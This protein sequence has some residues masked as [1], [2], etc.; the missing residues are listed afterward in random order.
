MP[1]RRSAAVFLLLGVAF[2][3][4]LVSRDGSN[5][6]GNRKRNRARRRTS[7]NLL[8]STTDTTHPTATN[9]P[10]C[11][12]GNPDGL[13]D[14]PLLLY[15]YSRTGS[16]WL[17]WSGKTLRSKTRP[18]RWTHEAHGKCLA[19]DSTAKTDDL[20]TW[21]AE[22][23]G[24][25][26][27]GSFIS[28]DNKHGMEP[29]CLVTAGKKDKRMGSLIAT[30]N[31]HESHAETPDFSPEQWKK[32]FDAA[33]NLTLGVLVRTNSV[34]RAISALAS[35]VQLEI[36]G[37]KKLTGKEDCIKDLPKKITVDINA[38]WSKIR[39]SEQKR[40]VVTEAAAKISQT[41]GD[42]TMFCLSYE[43]MQRD[44]TGEMRDLGLYLG[45]PI[46]EASLLKLE[47]ESVS[48]K[49]GS[50]SLEEYLENYDEVRESLASNPCLLE[51][52]EESEPKDFPLC[53]AWV[54][55][56]V[57]GEDEKLEEEQ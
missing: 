32:I 6:N 1:N 26:T 45:S 21:F 5:G 34:K 8:D 39:E 3:G 57:H 19:K 40:T 48:Y 30:F 27:D 23:F 4:L 54:P 38:L 47:E 53:G 50:D 12:R 55:E 7:R 29:E 18:M 46:D 41:Y 17:A 36:C 10:Q 24:R 20:S 49:R 43:S 14:R 52:L 25:E 11:A 42:G 28:L 9:H 31:P 56:E 37:I 35:H 13:V 33:P 51:Q 2:A 16:T 15:K 44:M 22:Y